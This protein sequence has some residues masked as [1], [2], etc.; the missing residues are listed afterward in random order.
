MISNIVF[1]DNLDIDFTLRSNDYC[2][3]KFM[4]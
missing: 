4:K 2:C 3:D 1:D